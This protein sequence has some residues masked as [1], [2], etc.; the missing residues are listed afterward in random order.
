MGTRYRALPRVSARSAAAVKKIY[1]RTFKRRITLRQ[2]A[3]GVR[4]LG[5]LLDDMF[6]WNNIH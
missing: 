3:Y 5:L 6:L 2:A 4:E 1:W